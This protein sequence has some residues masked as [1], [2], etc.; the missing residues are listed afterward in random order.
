MFRALT[1]FWKTIGFL[2]SL[3][4]LYYLPADLATAP[5]ATSAW[6]RIL[7]MLS[8]EQAILVICAV[9]ALWLF[10]R[11]C[12]DFLNRTGKPSFRWKGNKWAYGAENLT[13]KQA[14][15]AF[16]NINPIEFETSTRAQAIF[17]DIKAAAFIG[18][19][20]TTE[21]LE[22]RISRGRLTLEYGQQGT[23]NYAG[24]EIE[25]HSL[26]PVSRLAKHFK[27]RD[28]NMNWIS[29]SVPKKNLSPPNIA[30]KTPPKTRLD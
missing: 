19:I 23:P 27:D 21:T 13:A 2:A 15:C 9:V 20:P 24:Q 29:P 7:A 1:Y 25:E 22:S 3:V 30:D 6:Q 26:M 12:R 11:D 4:G 17:S 8:K 28:W 14:A 16:A 18:W 10:Y 5:D